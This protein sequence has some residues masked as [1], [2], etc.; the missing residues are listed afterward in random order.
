MVYKLQ[1]Q[2]R[3]PGYDYS[4]DGY[5]FV[6]ICTRGRECL[7]GEVRDNQMQLSQ[8]GKVIDGFWTKIPD[9]FTYAQ[10]DEFVV[11]PNHVHGII[12]ID[13][14]RRNGRRNGRKTVRKPKIRHGLSTVPTVISKKHLQPQPKSLS[15]IVR[16]YKAAVTGESRRQNYSHDLW[17][18]RFHDHVI[19]DE[20]S[21][22]RIRL[23]I[24]ENVFNW[25]KDRNNPEYSD[26]SNRASSG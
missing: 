9:H 25:G 18:P 6:T 2:Y 21:L 19:R 1:K 15:I 26:L 23:Y 14:G 4:L 17:Q 20:D 3:L 12:V 8:L 5:Y 22:N 10:M 24:Q 13:H 11:M 16:N 7:F